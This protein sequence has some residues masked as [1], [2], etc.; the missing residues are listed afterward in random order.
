[1]TSSRSVRG[2]RRGLGGVARFVVRLPALALIG[3][4]RGWQLVV[5]PWYGQTCRFYPSCSSYG[6]EA[7]RR[8]GA[9]RGL[10]LTAWRLLRCNPWNPGGVDPVPLRDGATR[11][12]DPATPAG[13]PGTEP[14][15]RVGVTEAADSVAAVVRVA[16]GTEHG[17][18]GRRAPLGGRAA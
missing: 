14:I 12:G 2:V 10:G 13:R 17:S 16:D 11:P 7:L 18:V 6:I 5:S 9:L 4:V 1:M 8:H 3:F 15:R